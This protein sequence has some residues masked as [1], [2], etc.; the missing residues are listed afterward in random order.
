MVYIY[1]YMGPF[2]YFFGFVFFTSCERKLFVSTKI[3]GSQKADW[4]T[5]QHEHN[6]D[7]HVKR[8][9]STVAIDAK[10]AQPDRTLT[11]GFDSPWLTIIIKLKMNNSA[12]MQMQEMF[13]FIQTKELDYFIEQSVANQLFVTLKW[14]TC[15]VVSREYRAA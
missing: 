10:H 11:E 1:I 15:C 7:V 6:R 3:V 4:Q 9:K 14:V 2:L 12:V 8:R 5:P 13:S